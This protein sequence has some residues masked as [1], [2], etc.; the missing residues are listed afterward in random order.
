[1]EAN[2]RAVLAGLVASAV[3][4]PSSLAKPAHSESELM[5]IGRELIRAIEADQAAWCR[6]A[7]ISDD[8]CDAQWRDDGVLIVRPEDV[9]LG[10]PG[11]TR[12]MEYL[13]DGR[14]GVYHKNEV[15]QMRDGCFVKVD[16]QKK[17]AEAPDK[18]EEIKILTTTERFS[19]E[20]TKRTAEIIEAWDRRALEIA[21][22]DFEGQEEQAMEIA[23]SN[24]EIATS[25]AEQ[26][27]NIPARTLEEFELKLKAFSWS[28]KGLNH[29]KGPDCIVNSEIDEI[30]AR[31]LFSI[32]EDARTAFG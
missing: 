12:A 21:A 6:L 16:V 8:R 10:V 2:R 7:E 26:V 15:D 17:K 27:A 24:S 28:F 5:T 3:P 32:I 13:K 22:M 11:A 1:M 14:I 19:P 23:R 18:P 30:G 20:L 25:L 29:V 9:P 4:V 31:L